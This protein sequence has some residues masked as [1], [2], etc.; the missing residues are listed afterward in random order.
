MVKLAKSG[1][2]A[3]ATILEGPSEK[4]VRSFLVGRDTEA[5]AI[6]A[7]RSLMDIYPKDQVVLRRRLTQPEIEA[8]QLQD[9]TVQVLASA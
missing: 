7:V 1:W 2:V 3:E 8:K 5:E 6:A 4:A 9:G